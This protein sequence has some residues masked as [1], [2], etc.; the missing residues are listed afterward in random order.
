MKSKIFTVVTAIF[1][2]LIIF[3][4]SNKLFHFLP[5]PTDLSEALMKDNQ[6]LLEIS[7]LMPLAGMVEILGGLFLLMPK[8]RALGALMIFPIMVGALLV[9]L[10][11]APEGL[12]IMLVVW[13]ILGWIMWENRDKYLGLIK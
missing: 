12:I 11:V 7:W 2:L 13:A 10:T 4:G 3:S 8:T 5:E 6:A 1:S 9:H